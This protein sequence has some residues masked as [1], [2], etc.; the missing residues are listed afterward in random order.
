MKYFN[1]IFLKF[2]IVAIVILVA[3]SFLTKAQPLVFKPQSDSGFTFFNTIFKAATGAPA[4]FKTEL[5][6][7][8]ILRDSLL[9]YAKSLLGRPYRSGGKNPRGFDCSGFT[10][11]V[12]ASLGM[13]LPAS[14]P[15]QSV[16]GEK[17]NKNEAKKG[18]LAFFGWKGKRG[19]FFVNHAAI[20][21]SNPGEPLKIIHSASGKG[22]VVTNIKNSKYWS[23]TFLFTSTV[24]H[25]FSKISN[26]LAGNEEL[27]QGNTG[28]LL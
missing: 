28:P 20:V 17:I 1:Q 2:R 24:L 21:I 10:G 16:F 8:Q 6:R 23:K 22:I 11:H 4:Y 5:S 13:K 27:K 3:C 7:E 14:S 26:W 9:N 12:F 25:K 19:R 15:A 18:D